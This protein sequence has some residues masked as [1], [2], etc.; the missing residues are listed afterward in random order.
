MGI[1]ALDNPGALLNGGH[2]RQSLGTDVSN[3]MDEALSAI[4]VRPSRSSSP[5]PWWPALDT[6]SK[7][8]EIANRPCAFSPVVQ[9]PRHA[10]Y[11]I[12][13][14]IGA[15]DWRFYMTRGLSFT[16]LHR[17]LDELGESKHAGRY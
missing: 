7:L 13:S 6:D 2:A 5:H 1:M 12:F 8:R 10:D 17:T 3:F 11:R 14:P 16:Q 4:V 15:I 9:T